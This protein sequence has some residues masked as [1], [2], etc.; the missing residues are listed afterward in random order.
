VDSAL[1]AS[2]ALLGLAGAPHCTVMCSAPCSA[3]MGVGSARNTGAFHAGRVLG[4]AAG[5]A[6]AAASVAAWAQ[7]ARTSP[8]LGAAWTLVQV[9]ALGLGLWLAW[10]GRQPAWM[11]GMGR[12]PA[13]AAP[14]ASARVVNMPARASGTAGSAGMSGAPGTVRAAVAG[15]LWVAW[16]CGLLQS[17]LLVAALTSGAASGAAAM[18]AFA[19]ASSPGLLLAPWAWRHLLQGGDP[20]TRERWAV[21]AAGLLLAGSSAWALG[22]GLWAEVAAFCATL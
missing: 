9:A 18:A 3:A 15:G 19:V 12:V 11:A 13:G 22:H 16:P 8:A 1:I 4:Y 17:G 14:G 5:G 6:V 10:T 2:A 21:R 7:W 20:H